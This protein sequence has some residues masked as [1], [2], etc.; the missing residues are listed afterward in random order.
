MNISFGT[1]SVAEILW[2]VC[3]IPGLVVWMTNLGSARQDMRAVRLAGVVNGRY[4]WAKF[5]VLLTS[6]FS[7]IEVVFLVVGVTGMIAPSASRTSQLT[8]TAYALTLGLIGSS[9]L[10]TFVGIRW[11]Q[12]SNYILSTARARSLPDAERPTR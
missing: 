3:S 7:L 2:T 6:V 10:I 11:R 5:S 1:A 4:Q 8:P 9:A 12:V